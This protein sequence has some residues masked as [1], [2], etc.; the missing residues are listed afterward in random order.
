[1]AAHTDFLGFCSTRCAACL[2]LS[3]S[4]LITSAQLSCGNLSAAHPAV[5]AR[6]SGCA[7][8]QQAFMLWWCGCNLTGSAALPLQADYKRTW[9]RR[10]ATYAMPLG[11][12]TVSGTIEVVTSRSFGGEGSWRRVA[13]WTPPT[14]H[15]PA[16]TAVEQPCENKQGENKML[17]SCHRCQS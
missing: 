6:V 17:P 8:V 5:A 13:G 1:M 7:T 11:T 15:S 2:M 4:L 10:H 16:H 9:P 12:L 14:G 3:A